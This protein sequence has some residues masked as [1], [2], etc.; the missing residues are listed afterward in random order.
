MKKIKFVDQVLPHLV[1]IGI[2]LIVTVFFFNPVFFD[3]KNLAQH[4]IQQFQGSAKSIQDFRK[5]TGEEALWANAMF[6]GMPAYL[7]SV[8]WGNGPVTVLKQIMSLGLPHPISNIFL[9]FACYY[10]LLLAFGIRPYLA[11]AGAIA[12]GLSSY[13]IVGMVAGHNGRVGALAFM[14]LVIAGVHL[15]FTGKRLLGAAVT[16]AG[17][18]LHLREN[19][20]QITYYLMLI[21]LVYGLI[22][23]IEAVRQKTFIDLFKTVAVLALAVLI[24]FGTFFGQLWAITEYSAYS[25]RGKSDLAGATPQQKTDSSLGMSKEY[26]FEFSN[27]ILEPLTLLIPNIYGG[28]SSNYFVQDQK[29]ESYRALVNSGNQQ[30]AN[31]LAPYTSAY[32]GEQRLSAPYYA[33]AIVVFLFAIGIA[34][35][36][37]KYKWWLVAVSALGIIL[38][39]GSTFS[40]FNY[41]MFDYFPG[42]NKF[43]SVTFALMMP[44]FA[45]PLLGLLGLE[46]LWNRTSDKITKRKILIAFAATGGLCLLLAMFAGIFDFLKS[47]EAELP[48]WFTDALTA[49]RKSLLRSDAFRS[50]AFIVIVFA[51]IYFEAYRKISGFLFC[52]ILVLMVIIDIAVVDKRYFTN[53]N[54]KRKRDNSFLTEN[55]SDQAIL[56]DKS[57]YRVYNL[58]DNPF[59]EARTSYYHNSVGGYHGAKLRRYADFYDSCLFKQTSQFIAQANQGDLNFSDLHGFNMLN[60]KYIVFGPK[61][62]NVITNTSANGSAWFVKEVVKVS[63]PAEEL[64][65]TCSSNTKQVAVV[66]NSQFQVGEVSGDS[67]STITLTEH[68]PKYLKYES[69]S[70]VNSL[71]VFSEVYYPKGWIAT[72]DGAESKIIR[73]D[74]ILRGIEVP[75]GKHIIEMKF[76]PS[77]YVVG[78]KVTMASSWIMLVLLLGSFGM[79]LKEDDKK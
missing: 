62:N 35:A 7:V 3:N 78:N 32:W 59:A 46:Q 24:G 28:A 50:F 65:K 71:A 52:M 1:A 20:L 55:E 42:Y 45:M 61:R 43:R 73:T 47:S 13:M 67:T 23:L 58:G 33:G 53:D 25:S 75:A 44:L 14:P 16:A 74:Y 70:T 68:N 57:Y 31:Q 26:A 22:R 5:Q 6:G 60:I 66:D 19:H 12:F 27:G 76:E 34:F 2:F 15:A 63:S 54:Y 69:N 8:E 21:L 38:S 56:Q 49:D 79:S 10:I 72:V 77:A 36:D 11:I 30:N 29:S 41:L 9:S 37:S 40:S 4:D 48:S 18:A 17:M 64:E 39:W 51:A